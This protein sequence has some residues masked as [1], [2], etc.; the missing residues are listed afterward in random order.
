MTAT[1]RSAD[2]WAAAYPEGARSTA[3]SATAFPRGARGFQSGF[4]GS[5]AANAAFPNRSSLWT[6]EERIRSL[7]PRHATESSVRSPPN[8]QSARGAQKRTSIAVHFPAFFQT[9]DP[10]RLPRGRKQDR[11]SPC[12][13]V[14]FSCENF[15]IIFFV[16]SKRTKNETPSWEGV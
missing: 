10:T 11:A 3:R 4:H 1:A 2:F 9:T 5:K 16:F 12:K 8:H 7:E 14:L 13:N 6:A 15:F